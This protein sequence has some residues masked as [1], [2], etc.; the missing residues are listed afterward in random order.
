VCHQLS[1][2][3]VGHIS[4]IQLLRELTGLTFVHADNP[5][6]PLPR[7]LFP[8]ISILGRSVVARYRIASTL[9]PD[10][11]ACMLFEAWVFSVAETR[12]GFT[13]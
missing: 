7:T 1:A 9:L 6:T 3:A 10:E 11:V 5:T 4:Q 12:L 8:R 13:Q 2:G